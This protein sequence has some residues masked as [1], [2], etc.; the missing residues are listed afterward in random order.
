MKILHTSDWHLGRLIHG[1][2]L[3]EDQAYFIDQCFFPALERE[4]P[5]CVVLAGDIFDRRIAPVEAI[6]LFDRV[7]ERMSQEFGIPLLAVA[8]NHDSAERLTMG[9]G[10]LRKQ[11]VYLAGRLEEAA[12][13]VILR[14]EEGE[15]HFYLIPYVDTAAVRTAD[16]SIRTSQDVYRSLMEKV[17]LNREP[18][19]RRV[20]VG[21][22][23]A[24]GANPSASESV[25]LGGAG[26][27]PATLFRDF[28]YVALGHLHAA[29]KAGENGWY[30]GSPLPYSFEE[31]SREQ[32][33]HLVTLSKDRGTTVRKL[34]VKPLRRMR[35]LRGE[36]ASLL[37]QGKMH[38][39]DDYF[40]IELTD[41]VP[42]LEPMA[43]LREVYPSLLCLRSTWMAMAKEEQEDRR[44]LREGI[45]NEKVGDMVIF[46]AFLRQV[47]G[48]EPSEEDRRIFQQARQLVERE[49]AEA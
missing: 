45:Q 48:E 17:Q 9:A 39:E 49:E 15:V 32:S 24:A 29:Q 34:P 6:R 1:R 44:K 36:F 28:D 33:M 27:V 43:R 35:I 37:E 7:M 47:C 25:Y 23:F 5:D 4:K 14:D 22:L 31:G 21:H 30:S 8:G 18:Q 41:T 10:L 38:H 3:L 19:T 12:D 26:Q 40:M 16:E 46:D 42:I 11:G 2:S 20:M 13:P